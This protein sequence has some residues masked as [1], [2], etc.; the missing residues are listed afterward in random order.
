MSWGNIDI[1]H[2]SG[3]EE[4][5]W[6]PCSIVDGWLWGYVEMKEEEEDLNSMF[7]NA[8]VGE[9][10]DETISPRYFIGHVEC[11]R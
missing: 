10:G 9:G 3:C 6:I 11:C 7:D 8:R 1:T 2:D 5:I 4:Y